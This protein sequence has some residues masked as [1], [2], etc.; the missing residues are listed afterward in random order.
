MKSLPKAMQQRK[1]HKNTRFLA[2]TSNRSPV[3]PA[4]SKLLRVT[5]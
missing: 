2:M 4:A 5:R 1:M 3:H